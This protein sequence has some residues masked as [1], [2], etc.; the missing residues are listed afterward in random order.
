M[1]LGSEFTQFIDKILLPVPIQGLTGLTPG[2]TMLWRF[3]NSGLIT[4][5]FSSCCPK[6]R[7]N[8]KSLVLLPQMDYP[9]F[10]SIQLINLIRIPSTNSPNCPG[11]HASFPLG[12][13]PRVPKGRTGSSRKRRKA[14]VHSPGPQGVKPSKCKDC[15]R[16][17]G[18]RLTWI[19]GSPG[20][21]RT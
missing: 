3:C 4:P 7:K 1:C 5:L 9:S 11:G 10:S 6:S 17:K 14:L 13:G 16:S 15:I 19:Q 18:Q 2:H 20:H 12:A 21:G 8:S